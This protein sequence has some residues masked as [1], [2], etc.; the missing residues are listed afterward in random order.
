MPKSDHLGV[1][2]GVAGLEV[3]I[4]EHDGALHQILRFEFR[5]RCDAEY[6]I[7]DTIPVKLVSNNASQNP[8]LSF[9]MVLYAPS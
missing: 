4:V 6:M 8:K 3:V 2:D 1:R 5:I 9:Q 7:F